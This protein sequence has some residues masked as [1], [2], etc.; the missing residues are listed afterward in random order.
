MP[1]YADSIPP[2]Y[3]SWVFGFSFLVGETA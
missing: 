3:F 1:D 2:L